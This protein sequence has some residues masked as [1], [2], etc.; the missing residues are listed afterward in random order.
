MT[1]P[2]L[3]PRVLSSLVPSNN[4]FVSFHFLSSQIP[5][6]CKHLDFISFHPFLELN[7]FLLKIKKKK[8]CETLSILKR[9]KLKKA[10]E[11]NERYCKASFKGK[12]VISII[13]LED[14]SLIC[15]SFKNW[16]LDVFMRHRKE[17]LDSSLNHT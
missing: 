9:V 16:E 3:L 4:S 6:I 8:L 14:F 1:K 12:T 15:H 2:Y 17:I 5:L 10:L 11:A 7:V 13:K